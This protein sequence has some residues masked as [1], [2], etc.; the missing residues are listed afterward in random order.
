[1]YT[2]LICYLFHKKPEDT[3]NPALSKPI[4]KMQPS[5]KGVENAKKRLRAFSIQK[6]API[7]PLVV[8]KATGS[9]SMLY[10]SY[11]WFMLVPFSFHNLIFI[12]FDAV[13][14]NTSF[15]T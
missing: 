13:N 2:I 3:A 4:P 12:I 1:M 9:G 10:H 15:V 8:P 5:T 11:V 14:N 7:T 6:K